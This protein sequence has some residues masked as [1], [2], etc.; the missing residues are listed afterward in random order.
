MRKDIITNLHMPAEMRELQQ[1][2]K[3][4]GWVL[5]KL[6]SMSTPQLEKL[7]D[8]LEQQETFARIVV[9]ARTA[10]KGEKRA[11]L[12]AWGMDVSGARCAQLLSSGWH[13]FYPAPPRPVSP[14]LDCHPV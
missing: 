3:N 5:A 4:G 1:A 9:E 14:S 12:A 2:H 10:A 6:T 7:V 11:F 13:H 8:D